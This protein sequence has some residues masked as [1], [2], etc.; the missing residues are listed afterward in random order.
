MSII[1]FLKRYTTIDPKFIDNFYK[2]YDE[3]K[4]DYDFTINLEDI[5]EWLNVAKVHLKELL[6]S[7]FILNKDYTETK[8]IVNKKGSGGHNRLLVLLTY[9]C[10]KMLCMISRS[11]K[12][13]QVREYYIDIEKHLFKYRD[14]IIQNLHDQV[15][16]KNNNKQIINENKNN[17]I[18]YVIKVDKND[19]IYKIGRS[20]DIKQRFANYKVGQINEYEIVY[21]FK[22]NPDLL[23]DVESCIKMNLKNY[24]YKIDSDEIIKLNPE[25][26]IDTIQFCNHMKVDNLYMKNPL[27]NSIDDVNNSNGWL[28]FI[29]SDKN[30]LEFFENIKNNILEQKP[31]K[32]II[33]KTKN[34]LSK[35]N[36]PSKNNKS[37]KSNKPS[38]NNKPS[39]SKN[40]KLSKET[41]KLAKQ[42]N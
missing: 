42:N 24:T 8:D 41:K 36:K 2:F 7:N 25:R 23:N 15:G 20:S 6:T 12:S 3:N 30:N 10:F 4:N 29:D 13:Q 1:T 14:E 18:I 28:I 17:P 33:G 40:S 35:N 16:I 22:T 5:C 26:I 11:P 37:S 32:K 39:K 34:T 19:N 9:D 31:P 27:L 21:V 38:K